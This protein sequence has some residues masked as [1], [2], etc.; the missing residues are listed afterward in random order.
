M[1]LS[2]Q[3]WRS[4]WLTA[5][6]CGLAQAKGSHKVHCSEDQMRVDI[7]LPEAEGKDQTAPQIYLEGLKGYP[8]VRCQPQI[9]G[10]L[11][12]FRLSLSDFYECGVTRMVNQ[13]TGKKVYYHKIIIE[14]ANSKEIVSVKCITTTSSPA[15][16]VMMN[17]TT[18]SSSSSSSSTTTGG[19]VL[20]KRDVLPAGFQ[21]PED[22]EI[23]TSLT[24]R[25]P[26]PRLSIGVSQD[27]Q[28][29]TRD[30]TVKSGTPLTMEINLDED[31][32]PVYG[33]GVNY[34]DVTDTH[35]S[36]ETLIFK[37]CTV[38]P[39]LFENFNTIDGDILSAKFKAFKFPDSSYVQFRA[40][41]NVCLDK[42][43][44]TQCSNNQ[45]GFGR[46][47]REISAA[48][49]VYEISVAMFLQVQDIEGVNKNE[50]LQLEEK[51]RELKLANQRLA[52]NSRG[53]FA[54][55]AMDQTPSSA[56]PAFVVD[57]RELGHLSSGS[58]SGLGS[59]GLALSLWTLMGALSWRLM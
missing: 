57:E 49:K 5:L 38:D 21:E 33:L 17:A 20:V 12:V 36:S 56:Q 16:N 31:S 37:G 47:K 30:L 2:M 45:V 59:N 24:K 23:T 11:A 29:F 22:L 50:V 13:L 27:G 8:D 40:T 42:C 39:Y 54:G 19:R 25:A 53:N 18:T 26:E 58:G 35:T 15:Y 9:D 4:L 10:S 1:L 51:L 3:M 52:R 28:K 44:G 48:N 34:L 55:S 43:L 41:V 14:S 6:F 46:R 32:A 7:G